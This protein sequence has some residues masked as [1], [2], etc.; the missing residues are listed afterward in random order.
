[1]F[2][3]K[4]LLEYLSRNKTYIIVSALLLIISLTAGIIFNE[5]LK[6]TLM[7]VIY[8]MSKEY[9][10]K[11][12]LFDEA[13]FLFTNNMR[14]NL[15]IIALG[16]LFSVFSVMIMILNG[17]T[18]GFVTSLVTP[19]QFLVGTVP[20]GIFEI[21]A[22]LLSLTCS[23]IVTKLEINLIKGL[24]S[25]GF[26]KKLEESEILVRDIVFTIVVNFVLIL[27]A[28]MIEA[29]ITPILLGMVL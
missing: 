16:F 7:P 25:R 26:R 23:F 17:I 19:L 8:E 5:A 6:P 24:L 15:I 29:G 14:A 2:T 4:Y 11:N 3:K 22:L 20:H 18:I 27:I 21:P 12:S 13:M 9:V 28:A 1:M 10:A